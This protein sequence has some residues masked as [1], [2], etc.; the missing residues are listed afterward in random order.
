MSSTSVGREAENDV[1]NLLT[2]QGYKLLD[3]NWRTRLCE[4]DLIMSKKNVIYFI[5]VKY[6]SSSQ[7]GS[8]L[9]YITPKKQKQ[10]MFAAEMWSS[11]NNWEGHMALAAVEM[12]PNKRAEP[13]E[14]IELN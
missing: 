4:I 13:I 9:D 11:K 5:E 12:D 14:L 10:M 3:Q 2:K 1:A 6:R 8:G 7:Y